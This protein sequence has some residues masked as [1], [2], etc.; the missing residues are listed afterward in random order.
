MKR[1]LLQSLALAAGV[2]LAPMAAAATGCTG[3]DL[4]A[5]MAVE[6]RADLMRRADAVPYPR[7]NF[8]RAERDGSVI[9]IIGTMH[10]ADPRHE[11]LLERARPLIASADLVLL[12][13]TADETA[14]LRDAMARD[15]GLAFVVDGPGLID[16]LR[17]DEWEVLSA[18]M[19]ARG[20]PGMIASRMRPF[21]VVATLSMPDCLLPD[22]AAAG[23][24]LDRMIEAE[25]R[26]AGRP[27]GGLEGYEALML[28][29][30]QTDPDIVLDMLRATLAQMNMTE[31]HF[32]TLA[33]AY[34][35]GEHRLIWEFSRS[36]ALA[37]ELA[38]FDPK[39]LLAGMDAIHDLALVERNH[40]WMERL[41][42]QAEGRRLMV[43]VGAGHLAGED[44]ILRLLERAGYAILPD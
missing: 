16:L 41:L 25:A 44:G 19:A 12:E 4:I 6:A 32:T 28:L 42:P 17:P 14:R 20:I 8:W 38:G 9:D 7:G 21:M 36:L 40:A 3:S 35:A 34:F 33:N 24:G 26:K 37:P 27:V 39:R 15:P 11:A 18:A 22:I 1:L 29:F 5:A 10:L 31:D 43:A 13:I 23:L 30:D 2:A